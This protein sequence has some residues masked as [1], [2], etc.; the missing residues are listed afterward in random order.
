MKAR[1]LDYASPPPSRPVRPMV[2][3]AMAVSSVAAGT[4][5]GITT[6]AVNGAVS[7][8]YFRNLMG[9][10]Y[11]I[12]QLS[13]VRGVLE[14]SFVGLVFAAFLTTAIAIVTRATCTWAEAARWLGKIVL[15]VYCAWLLG[16]VIGVC[17]AATKP[18]FLKNT[19]YGVPDDRT[20][21]LRFA[22]VGGSIWCAEYGGFVIVIVG[23]VNFRIRWRRM[24]SALVAC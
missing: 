23:L 11:D 9:W 10:T 16:G 15:A 21:L 1:V 17:V 2:L 13:V 7:P 24:R 6:N 20:E 22:W 5:V 4:I 12:W 8:A 18:D 3:V 19:F 14:G